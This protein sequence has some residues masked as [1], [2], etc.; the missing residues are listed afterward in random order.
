[1]DEKDYLYAQNRYKEQETELAALLS[2]LSAQEQSIIET[3]TEENPWLRTLLP[4]RED[5]ALTRKM[6]LELVDQIIVHSK[7]NLTVNLRF[8]DEYRR[9]QES[10]LFRVEVAVNE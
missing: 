8:E 1:M 2:E 10:L 9:L 3:R 7:T 5:L 6:A 4:F